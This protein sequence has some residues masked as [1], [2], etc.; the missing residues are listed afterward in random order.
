[1]FRKL[2]L[3]SGWKPTDG[4]FRKHPEE[5]V[6]RRPCRRLPWKNCFQ[7]FRRF[8]PVSTPTDPSFSELLRLIVNKTVQGSR[9]FFVIVGKM[10]NLHRA[11]RKKAIA[12][13]GVFI[14]FGQQLLQ[15]R[16]RIPMR[17]RSPTH[18]DEFQLWSL[19]SNK[20]IKILVHLRCRPGNYPGK[21][22]DGWVHGN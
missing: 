21:N 18:G 19:V 6:S 4:T 3:V 22:A 17:D 1:M 14:F 2:S 13:F 5:L 10:K 11:C 12:I 15:E 7:V 16:F 9:A 8:T 20:A